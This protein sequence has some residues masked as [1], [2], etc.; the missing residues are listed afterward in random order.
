M[1]LP[2][3][4]AEKEEEEGTVHGG[5][6][7]A[8]LG[9]G[10]QLHR[11]S[12]RALRSEVAKYYEQYFKRRQQE[13]DQPDGL[14]AATIALGMTVTSVR[15]EEVEDGLGSTETLWRVTAE[16]VANV[17]STCSEPR[18]WLTRALVLATGTVG[19]PKLLAVEGELDIEGVRHT[20]DN[21]GPAS[22]K[23]DGSMPVLLVVGAG[24][25]A[26]DACLRALKAGWKVRHS[27][28]QEPEHT[29]LASMFGA[30]YR[31]F[32]AGHTRTAAQDFDWE[33]TGHTYAEYLRLLSF[34]HGGQEERLNYIAMPS[35]SVLQFGNSS[36]SSS[37]SQV[38]VTM[39]G[40]VITVD[41]VA[42]LIGSQ[43]NL[44]FLPED[45]RDELKSDPAATHEHAGRRSKHPVWVDA[46]AFTG[47]HPSIQPA[48]FVAGPL[49]GDNFVR[50]V[51]PD[52]FG[53]VAR[54]ADIL[55]KRSQK[56]GQQCL[57]RE[58]D[59]SAIMN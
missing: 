44:G 23:P 17:S 53:I 20:F 33:G 43:P 55:E 27:F 48:L 10:D 29:K 30:D 14:P 16:P 13:N 15:R 32:S 57:L 34:M 45:V 38:S 26:A 24:L 21:S 49:R 11:Q 47:Q 58:K 2:E 39:L 6:H 9:E 42:V 22:P 40:E 50:F 52:A 56:K 18:S 12:A 19:L 59:S 1:I 41:R 7:G 4:E 36:S 46:D 31:Y 5:L 28:R 35:T 25:T 51:W 37:K 3:E 8:P 54:L